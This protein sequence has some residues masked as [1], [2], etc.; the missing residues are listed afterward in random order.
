MNPSDVIRVDLK[1][2]ASKRIETLPTTFGAN[3]CT[4]LRGGSRQGFAV[5]PGPLKGYPPWV[6]V[7][8]LDGA[9]VS[10]FV[11]YDDEGA[12][13]ANLGSVDVDGDG[14][15]ELIVGDGVGTSLPGKVRIH[16]LDGTLVAQWEAYSKF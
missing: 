8:D 4:I 14:T 6:R 1:G 13:G 15:D 10:E 9:M 11:A 7:F 3:V 16:R 5:A 2:G 12:C